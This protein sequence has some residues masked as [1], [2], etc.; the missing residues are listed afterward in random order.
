MKNPAKTIGFQFIFGFSGLDEQYSRNF[1]FY[2][3]MLGHL[4]KLSQ[5][6]GDKMELGIEGLGVQYQ[7]VMAA[8]K[9]D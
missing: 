8:D 5:Q 1:R 2:G 4:K 7:N 9:L 3:D 6:V